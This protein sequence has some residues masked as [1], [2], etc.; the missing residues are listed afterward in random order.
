VAPK[1]NRVAK[2]RITDIDWYLHHRYGAGLPNDDAGREDLVL[3]L[4]HIAQNRENPY[5]KMIRAA[6]LW[7]LWMPR[8]EAEA[9]VAQ[10]LEKPR[11]YQAKTLGRLMRLTR[12]EHQ[13]GH[14]QTIRPFDKDDAEV[15]E[16]TRRKDR[17]KKRAKRQRNGAVSR[18]EYL[19][20]SKSRSEP[21]KPLGMSRPT[22][23]R[24]LKA[25]E[26]S[27]ETSASH[28]LEDSYGRDTPVSHEAYPTTPTLKPIV[29]R[30]EQV[31]DCR[32]PQVSRR[33]EIIIEGEILP[34]GGCAW[35]PPPG[36]HTARALAYAR[37]VIEQEGRLQ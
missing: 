20:N 11:R 18:E 19:A 3:L 28:P 29:L 1:I 23:Y 6:R 10:I 36:S 2:L 5:N 15:A 21:W 34:P 7:A 25:G 9:L 26:I 31:V 13:L 24:K 12:Q 27:S 16:E 8:A 35:A 22:Y 30:P 37:K 33:P 14:I 17:E 32:A 4:N